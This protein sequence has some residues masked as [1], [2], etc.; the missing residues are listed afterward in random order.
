MSLLPA[1]IAQYSAIIDDILRNCDLATISAKKIRKGLQEALNQD[2]S[3][4]KEQVSALILRRFDHFEALTKS[5]P[6][7]AATPTGA[8][9]SEAVKHESTS[10]RSSRSPKSEPRSDSEDAPPPKKKRKQAAAGGQNDDAKLAARLQAQENRSTRA[11]RGGAAAKKVVKKAKKPRKK[12]EKKI[13]K[14]DDSE[15]EIGSDGEVKEKPKKGGF[16]KQYSLSA[17]LANVIGEPTLSRPQVVKKIWEYIK[18]RD[19]QDPADKRQILCDDKLQMV[20]KTEKVHMFTMNKIL[21]KQLY[22]VEE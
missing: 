1:E 18:A 6:P 13:A 21:S 10:P 4:K 20:F 19:L 12:S 17:P 3:D 7:P 16:H 2:I 15:L 5:S 8:I 9:K 11:T 22:D 14:E